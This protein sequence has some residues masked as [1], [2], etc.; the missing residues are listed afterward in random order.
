MQSLSTDYSATRQ[1]EVTNLVIRRRSVPHA[2]LCIADEFSN[3]VFRVREGILNGL[4]GFWIEAAK[5]IHVVGGI[6]DLMVRVDAEA[7]GSRLRAGQRVFR[8]Q[9]RLRIEASDIP[10]IVFA[11]PN[12]SL[13][14]D[15]HASRKALWRGR[16]P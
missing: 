12:D 10:C 3:G 7:I 4:A 8:K 9:L 15:L 5:H 16:S 1:R 6:P 14:V 2:T 11:K 13:G